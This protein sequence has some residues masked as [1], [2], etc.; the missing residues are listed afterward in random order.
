LL[1]Y[2]GWRND[3]NSAGIYLEPIL[4]AWRIKHYLLETDDDIEKISMAYKEANETKRPVAVLIAKEY[5]SERNPQI[6]SST[7]R[8]TMMDSFEAEKV[9]SR[10]RHNAIVVA[11]THT[12]SRE[13]PQLSSDPDLDIASL[14]QVMG[15]SSSYGLGLALAIPTKKIIVLDADGALLM[16]LGSLVTIA[17]K[18]PN[19]LIHFVMEN[20]VYRTTGGQPIPGTG[21]LSFRGLAKEAGYHHVYE[22][23]KLDDLENSMETIMDEA[24]PTLVCLKVLPLTEMSA[25]PAPSCSNLAS[26]SSRLKKVI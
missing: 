4:D 20:G 23:D 22:F 7:V 16:N 3:T 24:G 11:A 2:V 26:L 10:H 1:G 6:G 19:N 18:A 5:Q 25:F 21:K 14:P 17:N 9:I 13:W 15:K 8:G 12:A